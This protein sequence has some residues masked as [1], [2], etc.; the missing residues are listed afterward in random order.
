MYKSLLNAKYDTLDVTFS[1]QFKNDSIDRLENIIEVTDFLLTHFDTHISVLEVGEWNN[2]ILEKCLRKEIAYTFIKDYDN[3]FH[4]TRYINDLVRDIQSEIVSI[5][6][7][8]VIAHPDQIMEAIEQIRS[9][10]C[11]FVLPYKNKFLDTSKLVRELFLTTKDFNEL[12]QNEGKMV[13][14]YGPDPVGGGFI[15]RRQKYLESGSE[16][17]TFYG[18]G[19]EDGERVNRWKALGHRVGRIE[20]HMYHLSH[21]RGINSGFHSNVQEEI[22]EAELERISYMSEKEIYTEIKTW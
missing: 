1:L 17:T 3:I 16:N 12:V 5:W 14:L 15:A 6:D 11:D 21:Y 20:G 8:D 4:R 2:R 7:S 19:R 10:K 18:W 13:E 9:K 22:K